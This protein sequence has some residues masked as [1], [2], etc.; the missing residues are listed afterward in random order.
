MN[1]GIVYVTYGKE[2]SDY[3]LLSVASVRKINTNFG[4]LPIII[5]Q[6]D[7]YY[8][9]NE[10]NLYSCPIILSEMNTGKNEHIKCC[11]IARASIMLNS[12]FDKYLLMHADTKFMSDV[13]YLLD[14]CETFIATRHNNS[15]GALLDRID[16]KWIDILSGVI[17]Y[18]IWLHADLR[19]I[20]TGV[21]ALSKFGKIV[22]GKLLNIYKSITNNSFY[23]DSMIE[24][25]LLTLLLNKEKILF[26][27]NTY[28]SNIIDN[29]KIIHSR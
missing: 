1:Q 2:Y 27:N 4:K 13:S 18:D 19:L 6:I 3:S 28:C 24:S 14:K 26:V 7:R 29:A 16:D 25:L 12:P 20:N 10:L 11:L 9:T 5:N 21:I 23:N 22:G 17:G 8:N 15:I